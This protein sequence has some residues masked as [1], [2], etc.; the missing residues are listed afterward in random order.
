MLVHKKNLLYERL[1]TPMQTFS[2]R[3]VMCFFP[4][5]PLFFISLCFGAT[6]C[7]QTSPW[8]PFPKSLNC[9]RFFL[10]LKMQLKRLFLQSGS[11]VRLALKELSWVSFLK[12]IHI[13]NKVF[14]KENLL[15]FIIVV[16]F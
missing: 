11:F 15:N 3:A 7:G 1:L 9:S 16:T 4:P 13:I 12:K 14:G 6:R 2:V 5:T 8:Q 10:R